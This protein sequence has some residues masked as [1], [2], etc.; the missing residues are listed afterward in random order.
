M[1]I[2][3]AMGGIVTGA[4]LAIARVGGETAPLLFTAFGNRFWSSPWQADRC[5]AP[6]GLYLRRSPRTTTGGLRRG[7]ALSSSWDSPDN[8]SWR[9]APSPRP[10]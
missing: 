4:M 7:P 10:W 9:P 6:P 8:K 1:V 2:P 5:A 3:S